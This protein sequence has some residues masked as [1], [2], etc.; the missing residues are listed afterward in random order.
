MRVFVALDVPDPGVIDCIVALQ[1]NLAAMRADLKLVERENLHFTVKFLREISE[2]Q[3]KEA[4]SR[5]GSLK[6]SAADVT[7]MGVGAFPGFARPSV[8][9]VGLAPGDDVKVNPIAIAVRRA[10]DGIGE[11]DTRPYVAHVTIARVRS[12]RNRDALGTFL[13]ENAGRNFG[14]VKLDRLRLVSSRLTPGGPVYTD[15]EVFS[16]Q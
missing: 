2:S 11:S 9:W 5:L 6:L 8:I 7:V 13:R 14:A 16:L 4:S 10:L 1:H 12:G 15:L 3:A